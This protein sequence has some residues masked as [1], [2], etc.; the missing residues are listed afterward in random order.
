MHTHPIVGSRRI[1]VAYTAEGRNAPWFLFMQHLYSNAVFH[2]SDIDKSMPY[3]QQVECNR[4]EY[5]EI[6]NFQCITRLCSVNYCLRPTISYSWSPMEIYK[7]PFRK[8]FSDDGY[9][10][11][12]ASSVAVVGPSGEYA[13]VRSSINRA[14]LFEKG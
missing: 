14:G 11:C 6:T 7:C 10:C 9:A 1:F 2:V 4:N 13:G 5:V 12:G 3:Q 8:I